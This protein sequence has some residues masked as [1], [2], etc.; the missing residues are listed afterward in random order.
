MQRGFILASML[1]CGAVISSGLFASSNGSALREITSG[2]VAR[3]FQAAATVLI[4]ILLSCWPW[5]VAIFRA[6]D[7]TAPQA[8]LFSTAAVVFAF[9]CHGAISSAPSEGKG[10]IVIIYV[11]ASWVVYPVLGWFNGSDDETP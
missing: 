8:F 7:D 5:I 9:F 1:I 3:R 2:D 11:F 10:W 4:V 6:S